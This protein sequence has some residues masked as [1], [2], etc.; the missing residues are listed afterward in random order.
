MKV[1]N[2]IINR[3]QSQTEASAALRME[4]D[5]GQS[6]ASVQAVPNA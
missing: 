4:A 2:F 6:G 1:A 5:T 3:L